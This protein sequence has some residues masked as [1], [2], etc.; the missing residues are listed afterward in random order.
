MYRNIE[1]LCLCTWNQHGIVGQLCFN[2]TEKKK[3]EHGVG[4]NNE[5]ITSALS[6]SCLGRDAHPSAE[7]GVKTEGEVF[8]GY[9]I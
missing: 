3:V 2:K 5:E 1:S 6:R 9:F 7:A 4:F 8:S